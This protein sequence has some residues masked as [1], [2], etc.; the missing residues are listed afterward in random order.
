MPFTASH[1][2]AIVP[3]HAHLGRFRVASALIIGSV[4][5]DLHYFLPIDIGRVTTH[6]AL[7]LLA[8][9]L[10]IGLVTYILYHLLAKHALIALLPNWVADR[11]D[12][13]AGDP[14][15]LPKK[16]W[17]AVIGAI[18]I[19]AAT[20]ICWDAFTHRGSIGVASLPA[21]QGV[22][23]TLWGGGI[24]MATRCSSISAPSSG[25]GSPPGGHGDGYDNRRRLLRN[26][27]RAYS[28]GRSGW[29]GCSSSRP[30]W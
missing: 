9:C 23:T 17:S 28:N 24:S 18:L 25:S 21:L 30:R 13:V 16:R 12:R 27:T 10:P 26:I 1:I 29:C 4:A 11:V 20:H 5:P 19:G 15:T 22:V 14:G 3:I 2:A 7:G 8:F 6:S